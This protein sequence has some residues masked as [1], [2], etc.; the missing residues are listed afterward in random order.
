LKPSVDVSNEDS[1]IG[2]RGFDEASEEPL[3]PLRVVATRS[4]RVKQI[5]RFS[6]RL[7]LML[8]DM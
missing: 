2:E 8:K 5:R 3:V 1:R 6:S 7:A 4:P